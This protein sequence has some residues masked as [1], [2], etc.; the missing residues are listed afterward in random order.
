M[1]D[2]MIFFIVIMLVVLGLFLYTAKK[3][4]GIKEAASY[5]KN[6]EGITKGV[7]LAVLVTSIVG[8]I[9]L[10]LY[11]SPA[12][13]S[14]KYSVSFFDKTTVFA[15]IDN[16]FKSSPM[17]DGGVVSDK[18]TSN[19]GFQQHLISVDNV[20]INARY[21]HH[22]CALNKDNY[23]YDALGVMVEWDIFGN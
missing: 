10:G 2:F 20:S 6:N 17:C 18:L 9:L 16:T 8:V 19:I 14:D 11:S 3:L 1:I 12:K 15:G 5:I 13:A 21:T 4:G 7:V 22:S 23:Q